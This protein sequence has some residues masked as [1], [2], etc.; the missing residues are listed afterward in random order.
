METGRPLALFV[1]GAPG[2]GKTTLCARLSATWNAPTFRAGEVLRA[3]AAKAE[4]PQDRQAARRL[5]ESGA[6]IPTAMYRHLLTEAR[7]S[8]GS[9]TLFDG[10]PRT[11]AQFLAIPTML[12]AAGIPTAR[13]AG[14]H[15]TA[16]RA[17]LEQR[18]AERRVCS[19][20][21]R[22]W[23]ATAC[24]ANA[25]P[26]QRADDTDRDAVA[27]R[28]RL[29]DRHAAQL[30]KRFQ[31]WWTGITFP[32]EQTAG[33]MAEAIGEAL[34]RGLGESDVHPLPQ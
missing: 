29:V 3:L 14:V 12:N 21:G 27:R 5:V 16:S 17:T 34:R 23:P 18:L 25:I 9:P 6:P 1:I 33:L 2:V 30:V 28:Q 22:P 13:V 4:R 26:I 32:S 20:C 19:C 11:P 24:C 7:K 31:R 10:Y 15:L 8:G